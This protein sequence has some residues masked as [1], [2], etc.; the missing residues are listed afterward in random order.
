MKNCDVAAQLESYRHTI[1]NI[2]AAL[3]RILGER[4]RCTNEVGVLK[5]EYNLP[6][7]DKYR[8]SRQYSRL[9]IL[10]ENAGLDHD[11]VENLMKFIIE[12]VVQRHNQIAAEHQARRETAPQS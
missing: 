6:A 11:F 4:F 7:V 10:A 5:A 12:E 2:D 3:L 8:E 1:D 9:R